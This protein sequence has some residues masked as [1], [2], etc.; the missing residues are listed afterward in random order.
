MTE[1]LIQDLL[2]EL[3]PV[4]RRIAPQTLYVAGEV[5]LVRESPKVAV[6]GSRKATA[7]GLGNA[8]RVTRALVNLNATVVSGLA[9]GI[10]TGAHR[11]AI[12]AGGRTFAVISTGFDRT[13]PAKNRATPSLLAPVQACQFEDTVPNG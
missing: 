8:A 11:S 1:H 2:G 4:H 3:T 12:A 7:E 13:Y 9:A 10:D 6:A 5:E